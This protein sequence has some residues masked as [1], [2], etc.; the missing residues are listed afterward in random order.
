MGFLV[1]GALVE[2]IEDL[3]AR[4]TE[5]EE[6]RRHRQLAPAIDAH[7]DDV[8]GVEL[9]VEP[10]AAIGNH[11][12]GEQELAR[13]VGLALVVIEEDAR[14]PVHL[15]DDDALG[16]VDDKG[17]VHGHE[18]HVAHIDVL[19]LDVLDGL[20]AR[21]L[22]HLEDDEAQRHLEGCGVGHAALAAFVDVVFRLLEL[23]FD[24]FE[25]RGL[26]EIGDR[27]DRA[28][29]RLEPLDD[30]PLGWRIRLEELLVRRAL[31]LDEVRHGRDLADLAEILANSLSSR[32]GLSHGYAS[33]N[34]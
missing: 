27:E 1:V 16:A 5:R 17:T 21:L 12:R 10:G 29:D 31:N 28:E 24:E 22:I 20:G 23:V 33:P 18:R 15:R 25:D 3:L 13:G 26:G 7:M 2:I 6:K 4:E 34:S 14:A 8:L 32:E 11:A 30:A 9:E 19:L